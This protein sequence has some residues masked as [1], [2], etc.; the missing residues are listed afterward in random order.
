VTAPRLTASSLWRAEPCPASAVLPAEKREYKDAKAGQRAH[1][2][3]EAAPPPGSFSEVAF[4]YNVLSGEAREVGRNIGRAY[5]KL[6]RGEIPGTLDLLTVQ[7]DHVLVDDYKSGHGYLVPP[8]P[9]NV[10]L[11]HNALCAATVYEKPKAIVQIIYLKTGEVK[12]AAF[13]VFDFAAIGERLRRIWDR[14]ELAAAN[15]GSG[16][17]P[18]DLIG[19]GLLAEGEWCWRC[20]CKRVCPLK[21]RSAA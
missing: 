9:G 7:P 20:E 2:A 5:G 17:L 8:L 19:L 10:Q 3:L 14:A 4:A 1:A 11:Q 21:S 15:L 6:E 13:D 16:A 12:D 18:R